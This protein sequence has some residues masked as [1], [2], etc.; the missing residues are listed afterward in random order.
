MSHGHPP[1][2]PTSY[3]MR[4]GRLLCFCAVMHLLALLA[5]L[6]GA[7]PR[8]AVAILY[9]DYAGADADMALLKKGLAQMLI[10]DL[11]AVDAVQLVERDRLEAVLA[12]LKLGRSGAI[13]PATAA[14]VG[15][16]LGARYQV[17]GGYF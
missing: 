5:L 16:L 7:A 9:F 11:S 10:S 2:Q 14:K 8:P 12:E 3:T 4:G 6:A 1:S 17:L 15:K 13:D